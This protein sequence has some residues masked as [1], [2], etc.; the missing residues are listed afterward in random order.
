MVNYLQF[1][2]MVLY[3]SSTNTAELP[4]EHSMDLGIIMRI[5]IEFRNKNIQNTD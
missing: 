2:I 4:D 3:L 1:R 5:L